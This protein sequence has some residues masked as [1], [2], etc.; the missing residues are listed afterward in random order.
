MW[1]QMLFD[2]VENDKKQIV[3][4]VFL[5]KIWNIFWVGVN[6]CLFFNYKI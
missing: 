5:Y 3:V 6:G 4:Y 1:V 2:M